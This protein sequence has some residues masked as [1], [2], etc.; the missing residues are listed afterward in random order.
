MPRVLVAISFH[1]YG[2][3]AQT[4]EVLRHLASQVT[5]LQLCVVCAAPLEVLQRR[6]GLEFTHVPLA[7]DIGMLMQDALRVDVAASTAAYEA[8]HGQWPAQLTAAE[9]IIAEFQPQ[10]LLSNISYTFL[11]AAAALG[12]PAV[13][14]CSLNWRDIYARYCGRGDTAGI[15]LRQMAEAYVSA[16]LFIQPEPAMPMAWLENTRTIGPLARLGKAQRE[17]LRQRLQLAPEEKI[18]LLAM[19][20]VPLPLDLAA[21]PRLPGT[22]LLTEAALAGGLSHVRRWQDSGLDFPDLLASVDLVITKSGYGTFT[23]AACNGIPVLHVTRPDWPEE[24]YL[25]SWLH[26]HV[27]SASITARKLVKGDFVDVLQKVLQ[28]A[29]RPVP[30]ASG[31]T[32]AAQLL[33]PYLSDG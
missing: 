21:W 7:A 9:K 26:Q 16:R 8:Y 11:A 33:L 1:G 30:A 10:L 6:I 4:A 17:T 23:E 18:L 5:D 29:P 22:T 3:V 14:L 15:I 32:E 31:G 25:V 27:A 2:H 20:G 13:A 19:G 12:V 28:T 24:A